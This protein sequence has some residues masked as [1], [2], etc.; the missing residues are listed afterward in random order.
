MRKGTASCPFWFLQLLISRSL[1]MLM[2]RLDKWVKVL[3]H[4]I[5]WVPVQFS[6]STRLGLGTQPRYE[7]PGEFGL[8]LQQQSLIIRRM[9]LSNY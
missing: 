9:D 3:F 6:L 7:A 2:E 4:R 1:G 5:E 8:N